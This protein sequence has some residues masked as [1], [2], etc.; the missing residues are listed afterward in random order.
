M[1]EEHQKDEGGTETE[2]VDTSTSEAQF[3]A[4][5]HQ[6]NRMKDERKSSSGLSAFWAE[7]KRRKVMRVAITYAVVAWLIIQIAVSTFEGFGIPVWVFRFVVIMLLCFFPVAI[8]LAWAF[9]LTPE[10]IKTTKT[11]RVTHPESH[12]DESH[13][14]K[15]HWFS[16]GLAAA[17]PT[18][19]FGVLALFFYI[20]SGDVTQVSGGEKSIAVLPLENMSPDPENA[21]F[22][23]G[24]QEEILTNLSK[25]NEFLVIG[26]TS[27]LRYRDSVKPLSQIGSELGVKYL[28]E[29]SV[30]RAG[31]QVR[32][33]VQLIDSESEG[34]LWA[35]SYTRK[36]EDFFAIISSISKEIASELQTV[37]SPEEI[38]EI[39]R[40]PTENQEAYD[41][42]VQARQ[43]IE[44]LAPFE[45]TIALLD[46]AV[47]L[48]P[49]FSEAWAILMTQCIVHW[50]FNKNRNDSEL[51]AK[52][53]NALQQAERIAPDSPETL[54]AKAQILFTE[55]GNIEASIDLAL[56]ALSKNPN[57]SE[58]QFRLG[59][60]YGALGRRTQA[61]HY[62]KAIRRTDPF[63]TRVNNL[64]FRNYTLLKDWNKAREIVRTNQA[65]NDPENSWRT[66]EAHLDYFQFGNKDALFRPAAFVEL[67]FRNQH[68]QARWA[69]IKRDYQAALQLFEASPAD[70]GLDF[71]FGGSLEIGTKDL[72]QALIRFQMDDG[73]VLLKEIENAKTILVDIVEDNPWDSPTHLSNLIICY[74]LEGNRPQMELTITKVRQQ[75][76]SSSTRYGNTQHTETRIAIAYLILGDHDKAIKIL[77]EV[78]KLD[79]SSLFHRE[80]DLW[81]IFDRLRGNPRFD[82]LLED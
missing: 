12:K 71:L 19:I 66:Q 51:L 22:A 29:G 53:H 76:I 82:A 57:Y 43:L 60:N 32:V 63:S 38:S 59:M 56:Q 27:T 75:S 37:L 21:F 34:H 79:S 15:R 58:A 80:L 28:L 4:Q 49:Q 69:L 72:V 8:I 44:S 33:T 11:A 35:E 68:E 18:L 20:R 41:A 7:L 67:F 73:K 26:R 48:D 78:S 70:E 61:N 45:E 50:Y 13:S 14:K 25:I 3:R 39:E 52:A 5:R 6:H 23:D 2:K 74:A 55:N 65:R 54:T 10:G 47:S 42:Y 62:F 77:E 1:S 30:Q 46:K 16:L 40:P 17:V 64:L 81:F 9:E 24:V 31:G 36:L